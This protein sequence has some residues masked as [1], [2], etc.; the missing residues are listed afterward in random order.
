MQ[1]LLCHLVKAA[2][3]G[4][5]TLQCLSCLG[6]LHCS[7]PIFPASRSTLR[8]NSWSCIQFLL[9]Y[10]YSIVLHLTKWD[11]APFC[12]RCHVPSFCRAE[13]HAVSVTGTLSFCQCVLQIKPFVYV[14]QDNNMFIYSAV[15]RLLYFRTVLCLLTAVTIWW[16]LDVTV[17][18]SIAVNSGELLLNSTQNTHIILQEAPLHLWLSGP[19]ITTLDNCHSTTM[20]FVFLWKQAAW[21]KLLCWNDAKKQSTAGYLAVLRFYSVLAWFCHCLRAHT[22]GGSRALLA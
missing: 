4:K 21:N 13:F 1:A 8:T 7:N 18:F 10:K 22:V 12:S 2:S 16:C 14:S 19:I 3:G 5:Q 17:L 11:M 15:L 9:L 20:A 6:E